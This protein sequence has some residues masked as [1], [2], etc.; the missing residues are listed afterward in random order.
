M[1]SIPSPVG[2]NELPGPSTVL[3][4]GGETRQNKQAQLR[5]T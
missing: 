3:A 2:T 4:L 1:G 5:L